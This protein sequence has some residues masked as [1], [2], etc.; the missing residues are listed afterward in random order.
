M[1]LTHRVQQF[2]NQNGFNCGTVDGIAGKNTIN[3]LERLKV[4]ITEPKKEEYSN[5]SLIR[6]EC[7]KQG[8]SAAQTAYVLATVEHETNRTFEPVRE[9][10]WLSEKW[11]MKNL[12]YAPYYGKS[13]S[14]VTKPC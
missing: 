10:Y 7:E 2:L 13:T 1:T 14:A 6:E 5:I 8:L 3:A 11:R 12:R 4:A 9:A